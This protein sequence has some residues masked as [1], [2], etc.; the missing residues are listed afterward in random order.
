MAHASTGRYGY[1]TSAVTCNLA[2]PAPP[3]LAVN[4]G[5][6]SSNHPCPGRIKYGTLTSTRTYRSRRQEPR[7]RL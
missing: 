1:G 2:S 6:L 5:A 7:G 3:G 4:G